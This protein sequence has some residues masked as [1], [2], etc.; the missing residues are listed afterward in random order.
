MFSAASRRC[1]ATPRKGAAFLPQLIETSWFFKPSLGQYKKPARI[2]Q[3][4]F[5]N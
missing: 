3:D 1:G 2:G 4:K 5:T